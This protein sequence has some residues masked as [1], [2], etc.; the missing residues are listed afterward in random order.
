MFDKV[1]YVIDAW[2]CPCEAPWY[3]YVET[4]KPALLTAFITLATFGWDDVAR[5]YFRPRGLGRRTSK[6]GGRG[7]GGGG[8]SRGIPEFGD[9]IGKNL[10]GA[11]EV[12]GE[13]W[14]RLG[15]TIWRID[16]LLQQGL[17]WW[18]VADV[19]VDLAF[20]FTSVLYETVWCQ[21]AGEGRFSYSRE[22]L[23]ATF[24]G[25]WFGVRYPDQDYE[26]LPC[27]WILQSG[28]TGTADAMVAASVNWETFPG[29]PPP[30]GM[31]I[32]IINAFTGKVYHESPPGEALDD[33]TMPDFV[34]GVV[35]SGVTFNVQTR[36]TGTIAG[37]RKGFVT[38]MA[39]C[40]A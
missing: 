20:N 4:L 3:I 12:K 32:R 14:S 23:H 27:F 2:S 30:T 17:F 7:K 16:T 35:P 31:Q 5:G 1:N 37:Y 34:S 29:E 11:D 33:G 39:N 9:M 6:R 40:K 25:S 19:T 38:C 8:R 18:L 10:P 22:D 24:G 15:K 36:H 26:Q 28:A 21:A 13:Q